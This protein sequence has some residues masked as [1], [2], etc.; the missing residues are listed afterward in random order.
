MADL[1]CGDAGGQAR[2]IELNVCRIAAAYGQVRQIAEVNGRTCR[3]DMGIPGNR[4][5]A[6]VRG[7]NAERD[8][9]QSK[10]TVNERPNGGSMLQDT[11][12]EL[13]SGDAYRT[14]AS[15]LAPTGTNMDRERI[16]S[17]MSRSQGEKIL[18]Q[19]K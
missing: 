6:R 11:P 9:C 12:L 15:G 10:E 2:E 18:R 3:A 5:S 13:K 19:S 1:V 16:S 17:R 8:G 7:E 4:E 14:T